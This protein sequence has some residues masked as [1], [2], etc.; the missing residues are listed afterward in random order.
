MVDALAEALRDLRRKEE[1]LAEA[2]ATHDQVRSAGQRAAIVVGDLAGRIA[3]A[4]SPQ[5]E[6]TAL[7]SDAVQDLRDATAA[8]DRSTDA[9]AA[10]REAWIAA[11][12]DYKALEIAWAKQALASFQTSW[13]CARSEDLRG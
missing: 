13:I 6:M 1:I 7:E 2:C 4:G 5:L 12:R 3:G 9:V 11:D 8:M 10:A